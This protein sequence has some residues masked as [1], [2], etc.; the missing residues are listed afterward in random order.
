MK[1][2]QQ[3]HVPPTTRPHMALET[4]HA[5]NSIRSDPVFSGT[6]I[7]YASCAEAV[8][9]APAIS[10]QLRTYVS[11]LAEDPSDLIDHCYSEVL[12]VDQYA[13]LG[14]S[15]CS[16]VRN[17]I[18]LF[19]ARWCSSMLKHDWFTPEEMGSFDAWIRRRVHQGI[20]LASIQCALRRA[21]E[22]LWL[23]HLGLAEHNSELRDELLFVI[24]PYLLK[25]SDFMNQF[26]G[27]VFLDEQLQHTRWRDEAR[28]RL[29]ELVFNGTLD[30]PLFCKIAISLGFDSTIPHT[31]LAIDYELGAGSQLNRNLPL[32]NLVY[33]FAQHINVPTDHV[34]YVS[35]RN[36]LLIWVPCA[37]GS[38]LIF[39]QQKLSNSIV[40]FARKSNEIRAIGVGLLNQGARGWATSAE[41]AMTAL[42]LSH[43]HDGGKK[44]HLYSDIVIYESIR[45]NS[46][47]LRFFESILGE[48]L[49]EKDLL[50][51]LGCYFTNNQHRKATA[52]SLDIH[53]NTLSYRLGRIESL[54]GAKLDAP[55]S[56]APLFVA[57]KM[58]G[59]VGV[60]PS[61]SAEMHDVAI[62][63]H[64]GSES[65]GAST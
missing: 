6:L 1:A 9:R 21:T 41:E 2:P 65:Y 61:S 46:G 50:E 42:D 63:I 37:R 54:L 40:A 36:R 39:N 33:K 10:A 3:Y 59:A 45:S 29:C 19:V 13:S 18:G 20:S 15:E 47:A 12:R 17:A 23:S 30:E 28:R 35:R 8:T 14:P 52:T 48:I 4:V 51:T 26:I 11:A 57:L 24:S 43:Y 5:G 27:Q 16:D 31:A 38:S 22:Q 49:H 32:E 58:H 53:P 25:F 56:I 7:D 44:V 64:D 60:C 55:S 34:V 62:R